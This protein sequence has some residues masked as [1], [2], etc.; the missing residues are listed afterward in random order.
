ML[1]VKGPEGDMGVVIARF[2]TPYLTQGHRNLIESVKARHNKFV[3]VLGVALVIPSRA[4]PLDF[5]TRY[6]MIQEAYPG[7]EVLGLMDQ[8]LDENWS[9]ELDGLLRKLHPHEKIVLYGG[10]DS[11][12]SHYSGKFPTVE[13]APNISESGT[14]AR[15]EAFHSVHESEDFR[16]GVC[17]ATANQYHKSVPTVDIAI[18][19]LEVSTNKTNGV[20][21][22]ILHVLLAHKNEDGPGKWR[23][24]GGHINVGKETAE[25]AARREGYEE[26]KCGVGKVEYIAS[27]PIKDWRYTNTGDSVF[28][29]FFSGL[30]VDGM[31]QGDD[32]VNDVAWFKVETLK[33]SMIVPEHHIL[34]D[35]YLKKKGLRG[36]E[37]YPG[38]GFEVKDFTFDTRD[39]I[40]FV[41]SP[42][43]RDK[44][45]V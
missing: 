16:R 24:I 25:Q 44:V 4:N 7:T 34:L 1:P 22:N 42:I 43:E 19:K 11:F 3:I 33:E 29:T 5:I 12:I 8:R 36:T 28:T 26:S 6:A 40:K 2:Q 20:S 27:V 38:E 30:H 18:E 37:S 14:E 21:I 32:D 9:K 41:T 10:R 15:K 31:P 45:N 35:L 13:L 39:G 17:Y 23:F